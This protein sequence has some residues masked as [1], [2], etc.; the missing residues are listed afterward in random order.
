VKSDIRHFLNAPALI[1]AADFSSTR[2]FYYK[3]TADA[4]FFSLFL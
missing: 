4:I 2:T 3:M 1:P